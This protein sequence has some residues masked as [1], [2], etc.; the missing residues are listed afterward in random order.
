MKRRTLLTFVLAALCVLIMGTA[1][2]AAPVINYDSAKKFTVGFEHTSFSNDINGNSF[3]VEGQLDPNYILGLERTTF[4]NGFR[5]KDK[6]TDLYLQYQLVPA[7][8]SSAGIRAIIGHRTDDGFMVGA[9]AYKKIYNNKL[10][11]YGS[12]KYSTGE[13][14]FDYTV[15]ATMDLAK[16]VDLDVHYRGLSGDNDINGFGFGLNLKL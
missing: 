16:D 3:Y 13:S 8:Q 7:S 5:S 2:I 11:A 14:Y 6:V 12:I 9:L 1:A 10:N 4:K 15:G